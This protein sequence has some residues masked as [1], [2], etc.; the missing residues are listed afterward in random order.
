MKR[1]S[2]ALASLFLSLFFIPFVALAAPIAGVTIDSVSSTYP[3]FTADN[4]INGNGMN[5][6]VDPWTHT[7]APTL[8]DHWETM[9]YQNSAEIIFDLNSIYDVDTMQVWNFNYRNSNGDYSGRGFK[10]V[11]ISTS[12]NHSDWDNR[13]DVVFPNAS[14]L[15]D[16]QG[17]L[18]SN[19]NWTGVRF[20]RLYAASIWGY[21]DVGGHFGLS[22]VRFYE[23]RQSDVPEPTSLALLAVGAA[24][25]LRRKLRKHDC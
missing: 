5:T 22:E 15:D 11:T 8:T 19:L 23:S 13:G 20:I 7:S 14:G 2:A 10:D 6:S 18:F 1:R 24:F 21:G 4:L 16:Y 12:A 3:G 9:Y 25:S 17:T